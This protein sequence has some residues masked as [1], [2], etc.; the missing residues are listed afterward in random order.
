M[1]NPIVVGVVDTN[2]SRTA[3]AWAMDRAARR[4]LPVLLVHAI[5]ARW[6][7]ESFTPSAMVK[8]AGIELLSKTAAYAGEL[9]P[10]VEVETLLSPGSP[11]Y[12]L[13]KR[14]KGA[15]MVVI[16]TGHNWPGGPVA[17]RALQIAAVAR[18]PVAVVGEQ[19]MTGRRGVVVGADGS[20]ESTQAVSFAAAEADSDGQEL[21]VVHAVLAPPHLERAMPAANFNEAVVEE[22]RIILAETVA[23][24]AENYPDLVVHQVLMS[25]NEPAEALVSAAAN[26]KLLVLGSRG[27]G[28]FKRLLMGSTAHSVLRS[29]PCPTVVT[30]VRRVKHPD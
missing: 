2:A 15:S 30:R 10:S 13:R 22:E 7:D 4:K 23:G 11:G 3:L 19:D 20:A 25:H 5:D 21:T 8:A 29:L 26:A 16:G 1:K 14:S 27:R 12:A 6:I 28:S 9:E 17:D 24:L 18:C